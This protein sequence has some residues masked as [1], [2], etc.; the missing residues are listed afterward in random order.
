MTKRRKTA[1]EP[2]VAVFCRC[3]A[4][5]FGQHAINNPVIADHEARCGPRISAAQF[6]RRGFRLK[7]PKSWT[8]AAIRVR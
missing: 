7:W 6:E 2:R 1:T 3:G 8:K 4:Q 5:W